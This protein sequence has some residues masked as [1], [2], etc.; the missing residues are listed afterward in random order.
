MFG[1]QTRPIIVGR[2][3]MLIWNKMA[4]CYQTCLIVVYD[5]M[6][7][8]VQIFIKHDQTRGCFVKKECLIVLAIGR[9]RQHFPFR[10][11]LTD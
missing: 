9:Q 11:V 2:P 10:Q 6:F 1:V 4:K 7:V 8:D 3:D 5:Q